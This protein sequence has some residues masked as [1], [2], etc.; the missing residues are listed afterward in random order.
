MTGLGKAFISLDFEGL[1]FVVSRRQLDPKGRLWEEGRR[2]ATGLICTVVE[3]LLMNGFDSVVIADS[4]G[5]MVNIHPEDL[6]EKTSLVRGYPRRL[7]M[8]AGAEG[9]SAAVFLGYH[10][11]FGARYATFDHTYSGSVVRSVRINGMTVSEY[12]LNAFALGEMGVPLILVAGDAA[13]AEEVKALTPWAEFVPFKQSLGRNAAVSP[14]LKELKRNLVSAVS[15]AVERLKEGGVRP[16]VAQRPVTLEIEFLS[17]LYADVAELH[18]GVER[19][20]GL[21]VRLK[22]PSVTEAYRLLE[23][24]VMAGY[25]ARSLV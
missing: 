7:S 14:S 1:P 11:G 13:L 21:T 19:L 22:V 24:L 9:S 18:P 20:D 2:I 10:A 3:H 16:L 6:P 15:V 4:H 23:L 5:E 8:V 25:G 17:T 12:L